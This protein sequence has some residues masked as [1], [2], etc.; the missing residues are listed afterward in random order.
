[1]PINYS[2]RITGR[3]RS[4][5]A[6]W[7]L[8][9]ILA[10]IAGAINAGGFL[11]VQQYTSHM[12]GIVS[13]MAD[14]VAV[15][16]FGLALAGVGAVASFLAGSA[17]CSILVNLA[18]R[19]H[20][21]SAFAGPLLLEAGLLLLFGSL[22]RRLADISGLFVPLTVMLLCFIM[23]LQNALITKASRARIRTTHITGVITDIG[24]EL[25]NLI[26]NAVVRT[27]QRTR[28]TIG[29]GKLRLLTLLA[30]SFL[31]GGIAGALGFNRF[32]YSATIPLAAALTLLAIVPAVDDLVRLAR[33][34]RP[35][36]RK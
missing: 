6:N 8:G 15:G 24:M 34:L 25:G 22:G 13:H 28:W 7:H 20:L 29:R 12:T 4:A 9:F 19:L 36:A 21:H 26:F 2:R 23:G 3:I 1:M 32:G 14:L 33:R 16:Q 5:E 30:L 17:C 18:D 11:A 35:R 31:T 27:R 10:F